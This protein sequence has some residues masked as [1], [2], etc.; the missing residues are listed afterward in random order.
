MT[1]FA[2]RHTVWDTASHHDTHECRLASHITLDSYATSNFSST[3]KSPPP[4][5]H[6][7][8]HRLA[9]LC[10]LRQALPAR[11][12]KRD[13]ARAHVFALNLDFNTSLCYQVRSG[14]PALRVGFGGGMRVC[15][16]ELLTDLCCSCA[17]KNERSCCGA[18]KQT[19]L[20][21][22]PF[23]QDGSYDNQYLLIAG[24]LM[25]Y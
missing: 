18:D 16:K 9:R 1:T 24:I 20:N 15:S 6:R 2:S 22:I 7:L 8:T 5:Q 4:S 25:P 10:L 19:K 12:M 13:A 23:V 3:A 14:L 21:F 11:D 17:A